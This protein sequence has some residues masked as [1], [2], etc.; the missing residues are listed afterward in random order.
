MM[1]IE[2]SLTPK[3]LSIL[4][5]EL[6]TRLEEFVILIESDNVDKATKIFYVRYAL[7]IHKTLRQFGGHESNILSTQNDFI[8]FISA[9][10]G[11]D[12]NN[13]ASELN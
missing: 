8:S 5:N 1:N 10:S 2:L 4:R 6:L 9:R 3:E 7:V 13:I 11:I 12:V